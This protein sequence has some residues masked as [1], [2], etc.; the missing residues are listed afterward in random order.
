ML[1]GQN[2][3]GP[4]MISLGRRLIPALLVGRLYHQMFRVALCRQVPTSYK[5]GVVRLVPS[6]T[7]ALETSLA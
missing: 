2:T 7:I 3:D 5:V 4:T 6:I 1:P